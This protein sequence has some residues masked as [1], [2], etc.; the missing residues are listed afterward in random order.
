MSNLIHLKANQ[1]GDQDAQLYETP[2]EA[3]YA[4]MGADS[5]FQEAGRLILEP[6]CGPGAITTCLQSAGHTVISSDLNQYEL[7]WKGKPGKG[8]QAPTWNLNFFDYS[9][10]VLPD[11]VGDREFAIVTNPPYGGDRAL[12][13]KAARFV[14]H[15]LELAPRVYMLLELGFQQGGER[16]AYRDELMDSP[17]FTGYFPFRD[18]LSMHRDGF[19]GRPN[20]QTRMH[21]WYRWERQPSGPFAHRRLTIKPPGPCKQRRGR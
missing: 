16:C 17:R 21:A 3:V 19:D 1:Y 15:A 7:R 8:L 4:L 13:S 12:G 5:W 2:P 20:S 6:A 18:R 10:S 14:A 11:I 9:P